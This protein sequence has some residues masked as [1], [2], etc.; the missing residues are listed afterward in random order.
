MTK[1]KKPKPAK[2]RNPI[3][4]N[5]NINKPKVVPNKKKNQDAFSNPPKP[6]GGQMNATYDGM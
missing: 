2:Q 5:L 1:L 3:A 4:K 6:K